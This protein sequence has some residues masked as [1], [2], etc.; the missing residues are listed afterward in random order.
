[1]SKS[2]VRAFLKLFFILMK[3]DD[4]SLILSIFENNH[5]QNTLHGKWF[6]YD[7]CGVLEILPTC[8][9][10]FINVTRLEKLNHMKRIFFWIAFRVS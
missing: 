5:L 7:W 8:V 1:M 10:N 3:I 2:T 6:V 4:S 9:G